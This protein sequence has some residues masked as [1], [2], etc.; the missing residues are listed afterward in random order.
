MN[1]EKKLDREATIKNI[2]AKANG[3]IVNMNKFNQLMSREED[4]IDAALLWE[5]KL[6]YDIK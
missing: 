4:I 2:L 6:V 5:T 1:K 3:S